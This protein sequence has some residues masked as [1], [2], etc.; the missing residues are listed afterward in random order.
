MHVVATTG[1]GHDVRG[2]IVLI[3]NIIYRS[4]HSWYVRS[5]QLHYYCIGCYASCIL[6][7]LL[8]SLTE[9]TSSIASPRRPYLHTSSTLYQVA[10]T[11]SLVV[12]SVVR[13]LYVCICDMCIYILV[14]LTYWY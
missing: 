9:M 10:G 7:L 11:S 12:C 13:K 6:V 3:L 8:G 5:S 1:Q 14:A 4:M 2:Y